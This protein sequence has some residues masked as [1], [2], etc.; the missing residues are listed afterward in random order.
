MRKQWILLISV[1]FELAYCVRIH[2][3]GIKAGKFEMSAEPG[4][5][6]PYSA[7]LRWR[8]VWQ[9]IELTFREIANNLIAWPWV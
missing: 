2:C 1:A 5:K 8:V 9:R 4:R 6:A 3:V 7:D